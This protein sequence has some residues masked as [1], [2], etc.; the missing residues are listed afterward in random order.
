MLLTLILVISSLWVQALPIIG[1]DISGKI[2]D[3]KT[4]APISGASIVLAD[5][6]LWATSNEN[7]EFIISAVQKGNYSLKV[8]FIGYIS[9][10]IPL[11][12]DNNISDF[13]IK[14]KENTLVLNEVTVVAQK[15]KKDLNTTWHI[16][17][18]AIGHLQVSNVTDIAA[19]LPGGKTK[20]PDLTQENVFSLRDAG[21]NVGN[22]AFGTVV[23]VDGVRIGNNASF[24]GA[25][26]VS[27]RNIAVANIESVEVLTGVPSVEYGDLNSGMVKINT[28]KGHTPW[29]I[30][31]SVNPRTYQTSISKGFDLRNNKGVINMNAEWTKA[32]QKL[33][34]PYTSYTRRGLSVGYN[35]TFHRV[36]KF[37]VGLTGN[38]GGMNTK[39]DPD[40]YEGEYTKIRDNVFRLQTS[41]T[42]LLNKNWITNLKFD[43]SI[44]YNDNRSHTRSFHSYAS[45][46]PAVNSELEGYFMANK[47]PYTYHSDQIIDSKEL[48]YA[49]SLKYNWNR[50]FRKARN[51]VKAGVQWKA[52][53]NVGDGEYYKDPSLSPNGYR[54]RPY[55]SYPYMHNLSFYAEDNLTLPIGNTTIQLMAGLRFE[56]IFLKGTKYKNLNTLSP[57]FN[58]RW[59]INSK[60]SI[61]GGWGITEKLPSYYVLYPEQKYRDI[62]TFGFSYDNNKSSYIYHTQPYSLLHNKNLKWQRNHNAEIGIDYEVA[63]VK[64]SLVGYSNK[65]K[66]PY[67]YSNSYTPFSFNILQLPKG[68]SMPVN[69]EIKVDNQ[70]G[71]L[72]ARGNENEYWTPMDIKVTDQT[73]VGG[74]YSDNGAEI[75]RRGIE[76]VIDLPEIKPILTQIRMDAAYGYAKHVDNSL[77]YYYNNGWSHTSIP[78]RSYQ[79]VGI[80]ANGSGASVVNGKWSHSIDANI[81]TITHIP[82][83]RLIITCRLEMSLLK[84]S[85]NLSE[86]NGK[87]YAF[88]VG[89]ENN[90]GSGGSIYDKDSYTAI[91][92]I[93]YMELDGEAHPFTAA[94]ANKAEFQHLIQKSNNAYTFAS[95]GYNPYFS[96][97]ISITKEIGDHITLSLYAN[98]F[99][100]S[101]RYVTSRATGVET[102]FIPKFYYGLTCRLKF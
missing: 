79:Y 83:V 35:N 14:M 63:G 54:P 25:N 10:T 51:S 46:Q 65:T 5:T 31:M 88:N 15:P 37:E 49:A 20:N 85:R 38:I 17:S 73:F 52:T 22:A 47:L 57:R 12:V 97:N 94:E 75:T 24:S 30:L 99:T 45:E 36:F 3:A 13:I 71:M 98:N 58:T 68:F 77:S 16:G 55:S 67:R 101:R 7:G 92:P 23:E 61:R 8:S 66:F 84:R 72:Y 87:Q 53:G 102:I 78:N 95:D 21:A 91:W 76:M 44:F 19:L 96:A 90:K 93:A 39:D 29:N 6:Y 40:A 64:I 74:T 2:L 43:A 50:R 80:Y 11:M 28:R 62:Q 60:L 100:N 27:T 1:H 41:S 34:S 9:A 32:T 89:E 81:T 82:A 18:Y 69:S 56:N 4:G 48:D 86:Y 70:T 26:G 33:S 42:W 59:Q